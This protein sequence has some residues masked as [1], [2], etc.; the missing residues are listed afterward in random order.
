MNNKFI[1]PLYDEGGFAGIPARVKNAFATGRYDAV[2]LFFIDAFGWRFF[3]RFQDSPFN[4]WQNREP[5]RSSLRNFPPQHR[6]M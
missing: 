4:A 1:K 2:V 3:E 6:H 5:S